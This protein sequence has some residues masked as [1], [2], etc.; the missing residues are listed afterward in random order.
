M[1]RARPTARAIAWAA[2]VWERIGP[3]V[4]IALCVRVG[5]F[6]LAGFGVR[7]IKQGGFPGWLAIWQRYDANWYLTISA[8]GYAFTPTGGSSVNFFPLYSLSVWL[9]A[10]VTGAITTHRPY[11]IAGLLVSWL[12]FIAACAVLYRLVL[13]R[14]GREIAYGAV[15]L[16]AAF[17]FAFFFGAPYSESIYLL[18]VVLTF[19]GIER[20]QWWLAGVAAGLAG[21]TRPTGLILVACL[22]LAY[23][24]D[25]LRTRHPLRWDVLALALTPAGAA[26]YFAYC[27]WRFGTPRAYFIASHQGWHRGQLEL[28]GVQQALS[29]LTHPSGWLVSTDFNTV[30]YSLYALLALTFV[31]ALVPVARLLGLSYALYTLASVVAPLVTINSVIGEG[32]YLSVAFPVFIVVAYGLRRHLALRDGLALASATALGMFAVMFAL[33]MPVF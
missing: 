32:R 9:A 27:W 23:G 29:L 24:E 5:I 2:A 11:L 21:A 31:I 22:A 16:L 14:F 26:A 8:H 30:L 10:Q 19:Y 15:L 7:L 3:P 4:T 18:T 20:R 13:P 17:P 12:T 25:W 1:G 6:L 28:G 33:G